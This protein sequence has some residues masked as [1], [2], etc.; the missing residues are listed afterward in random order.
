[1]NIFVYDLIFLIVFSLTVAWFLYRRKQKL[2]KDGWMYLYKTSVGMNVIDYL[3]T[4]N[5]RLMKFFS[6]LIVITG[7]VL[8]AIMVWLL[9]QM[10]KL[11]LNAAIVQAIKI[12]PLMPLIPYLPGIFKITWLP[13]FYFTYWIIAIALIAIFHEGFHGIFARFNNVRIKST[14][15]GFLGPFLA[16][17]VEQDDKQMTSKKIFPQ[18]TIL[19]AGVFAN[20]L[21]GFIFFFLMVGFFNVAY[22]PAGVT[23]DTYAYNV[24]PLSLIAFSNQ[25]ITSSLGNNYT[26]ASYNNQ[27]YLADEQILNETRALGLNNTLLYTIAPAIVGDL[28]GAVIE[29]NSQQI[30]S[31]SD[32]TRALGDLNPGD[33]IELKTRYKINQTTEILSYQ[34]VLGQDYSNQSRA[35][36]GI[37]HSQYKTSGLKSFLNKMFY[38][39]KDPSVEYLPKV[40]GEFILFIYNLLWWI[41]LINFSVA[42]TNMLP[43]GIF[44]GGRFFY[45]TI[46][47]VTKSK[48]VAEICFK[49]TTKI[50]LLIF[51]SL[52]ILWAWGM[53]VA[54]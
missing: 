13:P 21:L 31:S 46:L 17:F 2:V 49:W 35:V 42:L 36:L 33:K 51:L 50:I 30:K 6:Y 11:F 7:Y 12:P 52:M 5:K 23:F 29:I 47:A 20:I 27:T 1:M 38:S 44:D 37:G 24:A 43:V 9:Y 26:L 8:M 34:L 18:L 3:G 48:K 25:T 45:L 4:K 54:R 40:D 19:G 53:F 32:I 10:V 14:G 41:V 22:A 16:F 39:F 28:K 15:F